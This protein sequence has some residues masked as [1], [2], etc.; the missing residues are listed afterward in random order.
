[1][2][3]SPIR[4][5]SDEQRR[6]LDLA[7]DARRR[8]ISG[9]ALPGGFY[10]ALAT[11]VAVQLA[12]AAYGIAAQTATGLAVVLAGLAVFLGVAALALQHFRRINGVRVDGLAS[13]IVLAAGPA[14]SLAYVGTFAAGT[15][16]AFASLWWLVALAAVVG[17]TGW[18]LGVR[19]WWLA[20]QAD[21]APHAGGVSPRQL[22]V[23]ALVACLGGAVLL[24][25]S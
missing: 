18:A 10:P 8:L 6:D 4:P 14:A 12:T 2:E 16:A 20:Y 13:Q 24:V 3:S 17:G 23:L 1:M 25:L 22:G 7:E 5:G 21:P 9:L 15:W 19:R 11:A